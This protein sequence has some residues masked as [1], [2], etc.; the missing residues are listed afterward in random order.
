MLAGQGY[1]RTTIAIVAVEL[2]KLRRDPTELLTRAV[3]PA[4]W[5]L[6]FGQV[7]AKLRAVPTGNLDYLAFL[8]PGILA[9]SVLFIAIFYGISVIWERDLGILQKLLVTPAQRSALVLGK[10]VSAGVR[11]SA[12]G[13]IVY[14][15]GLLMG[16]KLRW[17]P[18][19]LATVFVSIMLGAALFSTFS[20]SVACLV[21]TRERFMGIGQVL[22]MPLF[23]ASNAIY[24]TDIMPSWL[25]VL[26][27]ANPLTY[28]VDA[29]RGAM[30]VGGQHMYGLAT[31]IGVLLAVLVGLIALTA[32]LYPN[33]VR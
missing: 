14:L 28:Q 7:F 32:R 24:P 18:W 8:V 33:I 12:Q 1:L 6:V 31:D 30:V 21:K 26:S 22:T 23:F 29:L 16:V 25:K 27:L 17:N 3:Q 19:A 5:L 9:Q 15:L 13:V 20:L 2:Q 4:L 10:A 11:A